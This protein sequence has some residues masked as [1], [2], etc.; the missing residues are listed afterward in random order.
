MDIRRGSR[1]RLHQAY[2]AN[3]RV[4]IP[5]GAVGIVQ[6]RY[7]HDERERYVVTFHDDTTEAVL[8]RRDLV[9]VA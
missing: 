4:I 6:Q 3:A 1:V 2:A 7:T 5:A 8:Y 9:L